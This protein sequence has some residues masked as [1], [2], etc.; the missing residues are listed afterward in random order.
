[1]LHRASKLDG[2]FGTS[3]EREKVYDEKSITNFDR[4]TL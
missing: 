4:K 1:M 3:W 2:F